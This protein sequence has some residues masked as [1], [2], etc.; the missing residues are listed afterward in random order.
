VAGPNNVTAMAGGLLTGYALRSDGTVWAWGAGTVGQLGNGGTASSPVPVQV[1][2]LTNVTA[3]AAAGST[4]HALRSDG[5]VWAWGAG[6]VGQLGNWAT[7][8]PPTARCRCR[9]PD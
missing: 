3:I 2:G 5:T 4:G 7:A 1:S 9:C 8:A 6:T